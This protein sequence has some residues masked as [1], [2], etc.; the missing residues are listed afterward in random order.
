MN[1]IGFGL[2]FGTIEPA[3]INDWMREHEVRVVIRTL[4]A[5]GAEAY[6]GGGVVKVAGYDVPVVDVTGAGDTFGG[7]FVYA[8]AGDAELASALDFAV[9]AASRAVMSEG[10]QSGVAPRAVIEQFRADKAGR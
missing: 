9:A 6:D 4:A 8:I 2:A 5:A 7:A 10:P 3:A 1:E